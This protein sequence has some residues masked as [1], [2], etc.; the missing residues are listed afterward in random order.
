MN[1]SLVGMLLALAL[2]A[3]CGPETEALVSDQGA[4]Q[5][6]SVDSAII[7]RAVRVSQT[8]LVSDRPGAATL[9]A[10]LVNPW[11]LAFNPAGPVWVANN[12]S[13]TSTVYDG[14]GALKLTVPFP[15]AAGSTEAASPTGQVFNGRAAHFKGDAFIFDSEDGRV[16]GWKPGQGVQLR[17]DLSASNAVF[18]GLALATLPN[19]TARLYAADFHN[20]KM[21][22]L[23]SAYQVVDDATAFRDAKIPAGYAPFN[24]QALEGKLFVSY[25]KQDAAAHDDDHVTGRGMVNVF[26][27]D[28]RFERRLVT[29]GA[30]N[31]PWGLAIAG[32]NFGPLAG[33]LLVGN[34]GNGKVNA[35]DIHVPGANGNERVLS[36]GSLADASG[37]ALVLEGLW[38]VANGPDGKLYFTAATLTEEHGLYG[39]LDPVVG[40]P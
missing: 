27:T 37:H 2:V 25:A 22:V 40:A 30:L 1:K 20:G 16:Y 11:G 29:R 3:A 35:Y 32:N 17:A 31:S 6:D 14:A 18:K 7:Y 4:D 33:A 23:D 10:N 9:D 12:H 28:G 8:D 13:G 24:V 39:R 26:S 15:L 34:F 21:V 5:G 19:G 38:A 36:L